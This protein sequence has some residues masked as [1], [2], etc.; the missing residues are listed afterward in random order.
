M[1][2][3]RSR[4]RPDFASLLGAGLLL[5]LALPATAQDVTLPKTMV[6]TAY[7][8]GASGYAEA[9]GVANALM[10]RFDTQVRIIPS[11]TS[12][13]RLLP[14][15]T[16]KASYGYLANE[17]YFATE[18]TYDFATRQWGPQDLR[19]VLARLAG[20]AMACAADA[21]IRSLEDLKG[22]RL[23][24]VKGNPSLN[25]KSDAYLAFAGLSR[26]DIE[27][28]WFG[29]Y[30]AL[31]TAVIAGQ[32]DCYGSVT[33][34]ANMREIEASP[35]GLFWPEFPPDNQEGWTRI[36]EVADF[37]QPYR[38]TAGA[39]ITEQ[40]PK[41][42]VGYRYPTV[43]TYARTNADEVYNLIKAMHLA[44]DDYRTVTASAY[45]W[46]LDIAGRPPADAPYHDGA[47]RYLKEQGVWDANAQAWQEKRMARLQKV[48]AA[49]DEALDAFD[50][51]RAEEE[52]KGNRIDA[53]RAWEPF[54]SDHRLKA[55]LGSA[56]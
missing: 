55:G 2:C 48:M 40:N 11:G 41:N 24:Y 19:V 46:A 35:R 49:W 1:A 28:V 6:W 23:G 12:I 27:P 50:A 20:N 30:S 44:F 5:A 22:K 4:R 37:F 3:F 13:G 8:L 34:S 43:T 9:S 10:K 51:M 42:L 39:G 31:K 21:G 38:E 53:D 16:D 32:I 15:T 18:G 45:N 47:I 56:R 14:I 25:V 29:S 33:T 36:A 17:V 26:E 54:W 7:D 52:K